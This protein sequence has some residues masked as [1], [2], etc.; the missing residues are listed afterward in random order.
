[1]FTLSINPLAMHR[2]EEIR[3]DIAEYV[4]NKDLGIYGSLSGDLE[5]Y[6][7]ILRNI[8]IKISN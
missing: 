1:M 4:N 5:I 7:L 3:S 6:Y 8:L 2:G